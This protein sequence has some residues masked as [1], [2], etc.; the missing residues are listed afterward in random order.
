MLYRREAG[1][2]RGDEGVGGAYF[3]SG[4][5]SLRSAFFPTFPIALRGMAAT[6]LSTGG[7]YGVLGAV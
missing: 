6:I 7:V 3:L 1:M 5:S 4:H 2:E